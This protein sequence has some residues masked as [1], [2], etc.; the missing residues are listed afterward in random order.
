MKVSKQMSYLSVLVFCLVFCL[1]SIPLFA[2]NPPSGG[3]LTP[4]WYSPL[5]MGGGYSILNTAVPAS[6]ALNPAAS[7]ARQRFTL[8]LSYGA[9]FGNAAQPGTGSIINLGASIP[10]A[11]GVFGAGM[12]YVN[13]P[14]GFTALP[15][16]SSFDLRGSFAKELGEKL[17][18]GLG[19][20]AR[21][22]SRVSTMDSSIGADLG[23]IAKL[24]DKGFFKNMRWGMVA[25]GLGK[26]YAP[27][28]GTSATGNINIAFPSP[29]TLR[30]AAGFDIIDTKAF[31]LSATAD[32]SLPIFQNIILDMGLEARILDAVSLSLGEGL[33]LREF[34]G[35]NYQSFVPRMGVRASIP[36][37]TSKKGDSFLSKQ[38]WEKS[39]LEP[40]I[41]FQPLYQDIW[42]LGLG[43]SLPLGMRDKS[44]PKI[45]VE[46]PKSDFP[47]IYLSPNSDGAQDEL[48]LP[49]SLSD[50]RYVKSYNLKILDS[51]GH[52]VREINNK[53]DRPENT[54]LKKVIDQVFS[55]KKGIQ[56]PPSLSWDGRSD[57]GALVP[58]GSYSVVLEAMD[59]N[60]NLGTSSPNAIVI[61]AKAPEI[62]LPAV[63]DPSA[64]IFSP[65]GD[66]NKE[67][68]V[69]PATGSQE[70]LWKVE[71]LD[72]SGKVVRS[73]DIKDAPL[74]NLVWD[75][76]DASGQKVADG[77]Y[78]ISVSS[79]DRAKNVSSQTLSN[80][81]V[82]T[83]ET[84]VY[85][86]A[87]AL[88]FS[89]N[90]DG[91]FDELTYNLIV[92]NTDGISG[93]KFIID[94]M[95]DGKTIRTIEGKGPSVPEKLIWDGKSDS[96]SVKDGLYKGSLTVFYAKGSQPQAQTS[97]VRI[98]REAPAISLDIAP[99][100]FSPD[101]DGEDDEVTIGIDI[102]EVSG[103]ANWKLEIFEA[104]VSDSAK[105][106]ASRLFTSYA[107]E[108]KPALSISWNGKS[109]KGELVEA[110]TDYPCLF[111]AED[112]VGN[113]TQVKGL[114][115]VD[116]LV[117]RDGDRLKIKVPSIVFRPDFDD[118]KELPPEKVAN[119]EKVL[120]RIAQIL[121]K[122]KSYMVRVEGHA[123]SIG[124]IN[125]FAQ[126][127]IDKEEQ[128]SVLPL[129]KK[130]ADA[131]KSFLVKYKVDASRLSTLGLGSSESVVD[132]TDADNR[133]KNRR[134]EFILEKK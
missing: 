101:N 69:I 116:I 73:L 45:V 49:I 28:D 89:P 47:E 132:P 6:D 50:Q 38:G 93:W 57:S 86:T 85:A 80:I 82:D 126:D 61:D 46:A 63:S 42:A 88:G 60:G 31:R 122:Y 106:G 39:E 84:S 23:F 32:A 52:V 81:V 75:G 118:F 110:A 30:G 123:N 65:D 9:L 102:R 96:G 26:W 62:S 1:F 129:S 22:G 40:I 79:S 120:K 66:G 7:A 34:I 24:G 58:D 121:N 128:N 15:L 77:V 56:V 33:N 74:G 36:I 90:G 2:Y 55:T 124:K 100:P 51:S 133:W 119:N 21:F 18:V 29:F 115:P 11:A 113:K 107:G 25:A 98:D 72:A 43:I 5:F 127:I 13:A 131:V 70:D 87:S 35:G 83:A 125:G 76:K 99:N 16:G 78:A 3:E 8:D 111:S 71:V 53:E 19:L 67:E 105:S 20:S 94:D 17:I 97:V 112:S 44:P 130:R 117:I 114:I 14:P 12:R 59:D 109:Q 92:R 41:A 104:A 48:I 54:G 4:S 10:S 64:L 95:S 103:I 108:G 27:G 37:T 68:I 134:V 91:A